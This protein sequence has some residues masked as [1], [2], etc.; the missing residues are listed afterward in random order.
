MDYDIFSQSPREKF[1]EILF[2]A[3]KNLVENELE[4][5]FEKFIAMSEFCEKNGFDEIAQNSFISQ[6]QTL[7]NE[8]LNDIYIGLSG[9]ILSQNE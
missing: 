6:N 1:F 2:N 5:T 3:N 8:R 7:V 4:K 9:D